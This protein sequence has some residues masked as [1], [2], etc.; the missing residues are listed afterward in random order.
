MLIH[1]LCCH[2]PGAS[3]KFRVLAVYEDNDNLNSDNTD[4]FQLRVHTAAKARAPDTPPTIVE[5]LP[6]M[7]KGQHGLALT[8]QVR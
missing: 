8:W 4:V 5:V 2:V 3:Y 6:V 1:T 7:Y